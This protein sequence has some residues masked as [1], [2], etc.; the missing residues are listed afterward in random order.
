M[1][2]KTIVVIDR[3]KK[4]KWLIN[5]KNVKNVK[6]V[7]NEGEKECILMQASLM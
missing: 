5:V 7:E 6:N 1:N 3:M 2:V 4:H